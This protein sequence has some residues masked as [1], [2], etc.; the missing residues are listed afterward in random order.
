VAD[1]AQTTVT[2]RHVGAVDILGRVHLG[3]GWNLVGPARSCLVPQV[4]TIVREAVYG[5][6]PL[7][8]SYQRADLL[9]ANAGYWIYTTEATV[10]DL[11]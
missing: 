5:Y 7:T 6:D 4:A 11:R 8:S 2:V 1:P 9:K 3:K 10:V